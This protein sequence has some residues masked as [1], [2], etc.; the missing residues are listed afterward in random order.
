MFGKKKND[1]EQIRPA[2]Q[3]SFAPTAQ[4]A[5]TQ[6]PQ[7]QSTPQPEVKVFLES[8]IIYDDVEEPEL[9]EEEPELLEEPEELIE[10]EELEP[11]DE[12]ED[13]EELGEELSEDVEEEA[14]ADELEELEEPEEL[15]DEEP[16]EKPAEEPAPEEQEPEVVYQVDQVDDEE[17]VKPAKLVKLPSL[18]DYML[19]MHLS[20]P[21]RMNFAM[22][23]LKQYN[24]YKEIPEEKAI[25]VDCLKKVMN[26]LMHA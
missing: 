18:I 17:Y 15:V 26:D 22:L 11:L 13:L 25:L 21:M 12:I 3:A 16:E 14:S 1:E 5:A 4:Y 19:S 10:E 7:L 24:K 20:K 8:E 23:L 9:I 2:E 6:P